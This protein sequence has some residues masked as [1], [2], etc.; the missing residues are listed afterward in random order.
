LEKGE[1]DIPSNLKWLGADLGKEDLGT[2]L[3]GRQ[4]HL[5]TSEGLTLYLTPDEMSRLFTQAAASLSPN[6]VF[7]TEMYFR[8]KIQHIRQAPQTSGTAS[9]ILRMVGSVPGVVTD[10]EMA[11]Q[12]LS[13][14]GFVNIETHSPVDM[15]VEHGQAPPIDV[16]SMM[17]ARKPAPT[18]VS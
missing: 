18:P 16:I 5:I 12:R 7:I 11:V 6:G 10:T 15:M 9:F 13:D 4:A 2:V 1:I 3:G 8:D 17:T 14:A